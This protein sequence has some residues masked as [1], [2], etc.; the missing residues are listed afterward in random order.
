MRNYE[1]KVKHMLAQIALAGIIFCPIVYTYYS[2]QTMAGLL[3]GLVTGSVYFLYLY[4]QIE[5]VQVLS[6]KQAVEHI[7]GGWFIRLGA[8]LLVLI[9]VS[10]FLRLDALAFIAGFFTMPVLLFVNG[11]AII[12]RQIEDAK[13][14]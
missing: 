8:M 13:K 14:S 10:H 2:T 6:Q 1:L 7:R 4:R 3:L 9:I 11:M 12:V 5:N